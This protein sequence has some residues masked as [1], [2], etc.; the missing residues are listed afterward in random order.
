M[1]SLSHRESALWELLLSSFL[2]GSASESK[3]QTQYGE[4]IRKGSFRLRRRV[5][6]LGLIVS[7]GTD[8]KVVGGHM[9]DILFYLSFTCCAKVMWEC[10]VR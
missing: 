7:S 10:F 9:V 5:C 2:A 8:P 6:A 4:R 1:S 3:L